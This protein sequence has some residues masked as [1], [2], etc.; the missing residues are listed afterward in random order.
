MRDEHCLGEN[1]QNELNAKIE[2]PASLLS[3]YQEMAVSP[4][5]LLKNYASGLIKEK[6]TKYEAEDRNFMNKYAC[7]FEQFKARV[8]AMENEENFEWEDDLMDWEFAIANI[9]LWRRKARSAD[10]K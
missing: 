2:V 8:E 5:D 1:M 10:I 9:D 3:I 4:V 6:I 7:N